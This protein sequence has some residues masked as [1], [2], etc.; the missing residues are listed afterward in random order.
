MSSLLSSTLLVVH[1]FYFLVQYAA[2]NK[3]GSRITR[4]RRQITASG[5]EQL[6]SGRTLTFEHKVL[7]GN[8]GIGRLSYKPGPEAQVVKIQVSCV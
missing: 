6:R 5:T 7:I 3:D 4:V 1:Q 8:D 2:V